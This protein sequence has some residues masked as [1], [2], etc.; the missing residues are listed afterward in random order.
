MSTILT[1]YQKSYLSRIYDSLLERANDETIELCLDD[2]LGKALGS[3]TARS[4]YLN[5]T[6]FDCKY[7]Y[8]SNGKF[9]IQV[10]LT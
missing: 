9:H 6:E 2:V 5:L 8:S 3:E 7:L 4:I 10:I 1:M